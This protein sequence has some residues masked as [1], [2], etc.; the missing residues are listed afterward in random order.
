MLCINLIPVFML[1][2]KFLLAST[3]CSFKTKQNDIYLIWFIFYRYKLN[4]VASNET[5]E[6]NMFCFDNIA[7]TIIGKPCSSLLGST[8]NTTIVPPEI[9]AIISLKF[10]FAVNYNQESYWGREKVFLIKSTVAA[11]GRNHALPQI[12]QNAIMLSP[13]TPIKSAAAT[14][15][16]DSPS[17]AISKLSTDTTLDVQLTINTIFFICSSLLHFSSFS[18]SIC[19]H[20][21]KPNATI[22]RF[23]RHCFSR[24]QSKKSDPITGIYC[25]HFQHFFCHSIYLFKSNRLF[26]RRKQPPSTK[27]VNIPLHVNHLQKGLPPPFIKFDVKKLFINNLKTCKIHTITKFRYKFLTSEI[28]TAYHIFLYVLSHIFHKVY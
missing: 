14:K 16:E 11:Y 3:Y 10:R 26:N 22:L 9:T 8:A 15:I 28:L 2:I 5:V 17:T 7:K 13:S 27:A 12:Q 1:C 4:F 20:I 25:I 21:G 19:F 6:A 18:Y 23:Q 24:R